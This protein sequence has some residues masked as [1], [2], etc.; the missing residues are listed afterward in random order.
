MFTK[1]LYPITSLQR[2]GKP[3]RTIHHLDCGHSYDC[4]CKFYASQLAPADS[5]GVGVLA[6]RAEVK[7]R[8]RV[9]RE[10]K[11]PCLDVWLE[12]SLHIYDALYRDELHAHSCD[13]WKL[14]VWI[15]DCLASAFRDPWLPTG[16]HLLFTRAG[17]NVEC[18]WL[19]LVPTLECWFFVA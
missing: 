1:L 10:Q 13:P 18:A 6:T 9:Y 2:A 11:R 16:L 15:V 14:N 12:S 17:C 8:L 3:R 4:G 19:F 7:V 5:V